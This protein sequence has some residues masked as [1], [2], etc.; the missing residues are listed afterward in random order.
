MNKHQFTRATRSLQSVFPSC[1]GFL[2]WL[3][4]L[5]LRLARV[6][7]SCTRF[8]SV[9]LC[10]Q[11]SSTP[12][13]TFVYNEFSFFTV[14]CTLSLEVTI[15]PGKAKVTLLHRLMTEKNVC[16]CVRVC[17]CVCVCVFERVSVSVSDVSDGGLNFF[18]LRFFFCIVTAS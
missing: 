18:L 4:S 6:L 5:L 16:V 7:Q 12:S 15:T 9:Q 3:N 14:S 17:V 8:F 1:N 13:G 10:P 2:C 11:D